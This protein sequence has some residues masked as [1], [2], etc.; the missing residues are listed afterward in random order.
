MATGAPFS[1]LTQQRRFGARLLAA[2]FADRRMRRLGPLVRRAAV[3]HLI[4][5]EEQ[6]G[7]A[8]RQT[9]LGQRQGLHHVDMRGALRI[10]GAGG[11]ARDGG[12]ETHGLRPRRRRPVVERRGKIEKRPVGRDTIAA[13]RRRRDRF[14]L[15]L[16]RA[17]GRR[18]DFG[19][20]ADDEEHPSALRHGRKF[21]LRS[22][23]GAAV[24]Q[25]TL[26]FTFNDLDTR[27]AIWA[28][29]NP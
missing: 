16:H 9:L 1:M 12:A 14:A 6:H 8:A 27:A 25:A 2:V 10:V 29:A 28:G 13:P 20:T 3:E 19:I 11:K 4:G 5:G 18:A 21:R 17:I 22:G 7:D 23:R 26:S 15:R 24:A